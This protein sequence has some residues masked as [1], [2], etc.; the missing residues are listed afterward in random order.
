MSTRCVYAP[1]TLISSLVCHHTALGTVCCQ[2]GIWSV[3]QWKWLQTKAYFMAMA[4]MMWCTTAV[5]Q[6]PSI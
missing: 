2:V 3:I 6:A 1:R 4:V 5:P